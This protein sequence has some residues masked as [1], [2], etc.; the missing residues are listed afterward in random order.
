MTSHAERSRVSVG[1]QDA[2]AAGQCPERDEQQ[3]Q[4]DLRAAALAHSARDGQGRCPGPGQRDLG[5][6]P[7]SRFVALAQSAAKWATAESG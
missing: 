4:T 5:R 6:K 3:R 7:G 2:W 1:C